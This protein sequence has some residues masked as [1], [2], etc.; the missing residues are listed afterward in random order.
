MR[1][2]FQAEFEHVPFGSFQVSLETFPIFKPNFVFV[3]MTVYVSCISRIE[4]VETKSGFITRGLVAISIMVPQFSI[5]RIDSST[6]GLFLN[7]DCLC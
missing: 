5:S 2:I 4:L 1:A 3:N 6:N 7:A